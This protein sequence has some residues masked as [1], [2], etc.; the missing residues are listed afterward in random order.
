MFSN[1]KCIIFHPTN[2][3]VP[4]IR[5][6]F[7]KKRKLSDDNK[8]NSQIGSLEYFLQ[9][10]NKVRPIKFFPQKFLVGMN[11]IDFHLEEL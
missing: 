1:N 5:F 7:F 3:T 6:F 10:L 11:S 2:P 4:F 9:L 8:N